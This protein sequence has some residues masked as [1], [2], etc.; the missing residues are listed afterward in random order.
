[1]REL[2]SSTGWSRRHLERWFREQ[3][4]PTP[5]G[6]AQVLRI[7]PALRLKRAGMP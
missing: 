6:A 4:G 1:M 2:A 3:I 7:Q 5:K